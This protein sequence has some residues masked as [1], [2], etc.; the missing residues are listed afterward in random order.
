MLDI[1]AQEARQEQ[2]K[3]SAVQPW[4]SLLEGRLVV[5]NVAPSPLCV[6]H[7]CYLTHA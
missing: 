6:Y 7:L 3:G 2:E 5:D 4:M 1:M